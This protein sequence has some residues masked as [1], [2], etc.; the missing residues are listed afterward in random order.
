M[1]EIAE[2]ME[3]GIKTYGHTVM[4]SAS[5]ATPVAAASCLT[6]CP[7]VTC[8]PTGTR[9]SEINADPI[10]QADTAAQDGSAGG[11]KAHNSRAFKPP[12]LE[13]DKCEYA[14]DNYTA[15]NII[16]NT[17]SHAHGVGRSDDF[18]HVLNLF[19][20]TMRRHTS[21]SRKMQVVT[22]KMEL[23]ATASSSLGC[24]SIILIQARQAD[25]LNVRP[26]AAPLP[27]SWPAR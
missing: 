6:P 7:T 16:S 3:K 10:E 1:A 8:A 27:Q 25:G 15:D 26:R 9:F 20:E 22:S 19:N 2:G 4:R 12:L 13:K 23:K 14:Q 18:R 5:P 17:V 11:P 24:L 21:H